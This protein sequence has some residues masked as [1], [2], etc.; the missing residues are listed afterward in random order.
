MAPVL[1]GES[2]FV[3]L[4]LAVG[5]GA[6]IRQVYIDAN[7]TYGQL[8]SGQLAALWPIEAKDTQDRIANL[9]YVQDRLILVTRLMFLLI[10]M[11]SLRLLESA[12]RAIPPDKACVLNYL[13]FSDV[14]L[15]YWDFFILLFVL[16]SF[17]MMW[18]THHRSSQK[19]RDY[20]KAM[21]RRFDGNSPPQSK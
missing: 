6:Y 12:I 1:D 8:R 2:G 14:G 3:L 18:W 21:W 17:A 5:L 9:Q 13:R 20:Q 19:E 16:V 15:N 11:L 10:I 4:A 7:S